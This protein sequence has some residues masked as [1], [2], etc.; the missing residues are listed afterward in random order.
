M[1]AIRR[2][3]ISEVTRR[4]IMDFLAVERVSWAGAL[5]EPAFLNR[6]WDLS[7]MPSTDFRFADAAGD[8]R[9]HR[10]NNYDWDPD[11]VFHDERFNIL[12][13]D[14]ELF[15]RF[16]AEILHPVVRPDVDEARRLANAFNERLAHDDWELFEAAQ[17]SGRPIFAG[18]RREAY[19]AA[20][21]ALTVECYPRLADPQALREHLRRIDRDLRSDPPGAIGSSKELVET[22]CKTILDDYAVS[23][24]HGADLMDLYKLVQKALALN[25]EAVPE[26]TRGSASA[27]KALRAVVTTVQALAELRNELGSGHGRVRPSPALTRHAQL[28]FNAAVAVSEFLL[29]TWHSRRATNQ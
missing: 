8:I 1:S 22:V 5:E 7:K 11:W 20:P 16:L 28:A 24:P 13:A 17:L 25:V 14:D 12:H 3:A 10:I 19:R 29:D 15:V 2:N 23:Y 26:S 9:Q 27:I 6:L 21:D 4:D 18:R